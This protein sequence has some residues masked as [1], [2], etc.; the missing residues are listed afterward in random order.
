MR[1]SLFAVCALLM[2]T[3]T[4]CSAV[5]SESFEVGDSKSYTISISIDSRDYSFQASIQHQKGEFQMLI[6]GIEVNSIT[7]EEV[8]TYG[9]YNFVYSVNGIKYKVGT[10]IWQNQKWFWRK[11]ELEKPLSLPP[12]NQNGMNIQ[13]CMGMALIKYRAIPFPHITNEDYRLLCI[14]G[15]DIISSGSLFFIY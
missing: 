10:A 1:R 6:D 12:Q 5:K 3:F 15:I 11:G 13:Q 7:E 9:G 14:S 8:K 2:M 4:A